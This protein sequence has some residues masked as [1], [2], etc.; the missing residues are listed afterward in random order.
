MHK[1]Y[2]ISSF[3]SPNILYELQRHSDAEILIEMTGRIISV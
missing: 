1:L 3:T 2:I